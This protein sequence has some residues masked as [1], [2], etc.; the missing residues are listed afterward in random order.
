MEY[1]ANPL[2]DHVFVGQL[3]KASGLAKN[4]DMSAEC[5][6][7]FIQHAELSEKINFKCSFLNLPSVPPRGKLNNAAVTLYLDNLGHLGQHEELLDFWSYLTSLPKEKLL[8][9]TNI[10]TSFVEALLRMRRLQE[11][12]AFVFGRTGVSNDDMVSKYNVEIDS[13]IVHQFC[14]MALQ[15]NRIRLSESEGWFREAWPH[16]DV[17]RA[18]DRAVTARLEKRVERVFVSLMLMVIVSLLCRIIFFYSMRLFKN[19]SFDSNDL[20]VVAT[21]EDKVLLLSPCA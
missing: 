9:N 5:M 10:C 3:Q 21:G 4:N 7:W 13:K 16:L 20:P 6:L 14:R 2:I 1:A 18:L 11:A 19:Y 12:K 15:F 8:L 17:R